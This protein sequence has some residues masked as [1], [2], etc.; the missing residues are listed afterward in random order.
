MRWSGNTYKYITI[1]KKKVDALVFLSGILFIVISLC[2]F[3]LAKTSY[4]ESLNSRA[5]QVEIL[6]NYVCLIIDYYKNGNIDFSDVK[7]VKRFYDT[8]TDYSKYIDTSIYKPKS[9]PKLIFLNYNSCVDC[10]KYPL[11]CGGT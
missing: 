7:Q 1:D 3:M 4:E 10:W 5:K 9:R 2:V 8:F 6:Q 11:L